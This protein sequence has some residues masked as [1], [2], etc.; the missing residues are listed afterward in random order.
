M[1]QGNLFDVQ[2]QDVI[3]IKLGQGVK[4]RLAHKLIFAESI[5]H[6]RIISS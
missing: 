5:K 2:P 1:E 4:S 3:Q 6:G